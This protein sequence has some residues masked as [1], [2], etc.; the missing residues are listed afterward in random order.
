MLVLLLL[1]PPH[2]PLSLPPLPPSPSL[3]LSPSLPHTHTHKR[4]CAGHTSEP[5]WPKGR[6]GRRRRGSRAPTGRAGRSG[7]AC[8]PGRETGSKSR[9][10]GG[11][12]AARVPVNA[13]HPRGAH[14]LG[15]SRRH[16]TDPTRTT[17]GT[18]SSQREMRERAHTHTHAR[19]LKGMSCRRKSHDRRSAA[20]PRN[21]VGPAHH[22]RRHGTRQNSVM[23]PHVPCTTTRPAR[24]SSGRVPD[25]V[26]R[27]FAVGC[28]CPL[29]SGYW[30][31][32]RVL[33]TS[34]HPR[35]LLS[36]PNS[37]ASRTAQGLS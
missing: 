9:A 33:L 35:F 13:T 19:W 3:Y 12:T 18:Q 10:V 20:R 4:W 15:T 17:D 23:N 24:F 28:H 27:S 7:A 2:H 1:R 16:N 31:R 14:L 36:I 8:R 11:A 22:R 26:A 5:R 25:H 37:V 21:G 34:A 30:H 32:S 29:V 6:G